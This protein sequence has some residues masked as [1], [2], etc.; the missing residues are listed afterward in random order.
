[1]SRINWGGF[2]FESSLLVHTKECRGCRK[3]FPE[4]KINSNGYCSSC[5]DIE[6]RMLERL[7]GA[8]ADKV[9]KEEEKRSRSWW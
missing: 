9:L 4:D 7:A 2:S 6:D 5:Q 1:M 8:W 3:D